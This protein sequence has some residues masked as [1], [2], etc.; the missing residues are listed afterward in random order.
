MTNKAIIVMHP[1]NTK[2]RLYYVNYID[3]LRFADTEVGASNILTIYHLY[4]LS[5]DTINVG[6]YNVPNDFNGDCDL[7]G[8][9]TTEEDLSTVNDKSNGYR[10]IIASTNTSLGL[11]YINDSFINE[12][13]RE[14]NME[15][16]DDELEVEYLNSESDKNEITITKY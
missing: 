8:A 4:V 2:S 5:D 14:Y 15:N 12:Y 16:I 11:P 9:I 6:D 13:V 10:K 3:K 7:I 1:T